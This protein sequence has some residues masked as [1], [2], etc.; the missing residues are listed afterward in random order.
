[1]VRIDLIVGALPEGGDDSRYVGRG[2]CRG[3]LRA[4]L[5]RGVYDTIQVR[6]ISRIHGEAGIDQG[7][8]QEDGLRA[9]GKEACHFAQMESIACSGIAETPAALERTGPARCSIRCCRSRVWN[10]RLGVV[11]VLER[12]VN[13]EKMCLKICN[14]VENALAS[15]I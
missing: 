13:A 5:R 4:A 6:F 10:G 7:R 1:M 8:P 11:R 14:R 12:A 3:T 15:I 2:A 9:H